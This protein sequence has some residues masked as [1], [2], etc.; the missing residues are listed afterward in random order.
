MD[1]QEAMDA[2]V[3]NAIKS[4]LEFRQEFLLGLQQ[5]IDIL[6]TRSVDKLQSCL[7]ILPTLKESNPVSRPVPEAFSWKI[8]R[9]LASTVPP[10]PMVRIS[11][12]DALA[13]LKR[14]CQDGIDLN[15]IL[16]YRGP[17]NLK[18]RLANPLLLPTL[19]IM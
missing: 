8:Q 4:R 12:G 9:K 14:L 11:L 18:V 6:Q 2:T 19:L 7:S 3:K 1:K 10:R 5:D 13:H 15:Q 16:D 17:S